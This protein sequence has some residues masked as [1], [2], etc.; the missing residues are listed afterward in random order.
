MTRKV[1]IFAQPGMWVAA[2]YGGDP[3]R[4]LVV[5]GPTA[6][7]A[8]ERMRKQLPGL[9]VEEVLELPDRVRDQLD[10]C[11][12]VV[13]ALAEVRAR[14]RRATLELRAG[15]EK[16]GLTKADVCLALGIDA[17]EYARRFGEC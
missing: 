9:D 5:S 11:N 2:S 7:V 17:H 3:D 1:R 16:A 10:K 13:D 15:L 4:D 8:R 12:A 14:Y 6:A